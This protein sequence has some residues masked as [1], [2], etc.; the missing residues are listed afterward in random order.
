MQIIREYFT[1]ALRKYES[2]F[3]LATPRECE[4][5]SL[6]MDNKDTWSRL[7][8]KAGVVYR[9]SR[10]LSHAELE[11]PRPPWKLQTVLA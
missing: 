3:V 1:V 4:I 9:Y 5:L 7:K 8:K 6:N 10:L 2:C 11:I